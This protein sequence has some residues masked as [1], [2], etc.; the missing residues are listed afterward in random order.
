MILPPP[1]YHK[2]IKDILRIIDQKNS[3]LITSHLAP[4]GDSIGS[5][6][7]LGSFLRYLGKKVVIYNRDSVPKRYLFLPTSRKIHVGKKAPGNYDVARILDCGEMERT[8]NIID[9][10][11]QVKIS[12]DIDHHMGAKRFADYSYI[13]VQASSV[14]EQI[15][16]LMSIARYQ[17]DKKE[18]I[19]LYT[20]ILTDT[21]NFQRANTTS[22]TLGICSDLITKG[23][24]PA[25]LFSKIYQ[26]KSAEELRLLGVV[27][28]SLEIVKQKIGVLVLKEWMY[29][30]TRTS[31]KD[32]EGIVEY[33]NLIK[34]IK[35]GVLFRPANG[36]KRK[37]W[38]VTFRST[39]NVNV[40][41]VA[42]K[43][44]GGGHF[45]AAGCELQGS[46]ETVKK[47][48]LR[49]VARCL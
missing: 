9:L 15:Y 22:Q 46:L 5:Q 44:G 43:F 1:Q 25:Y 4:D 8:G 3:F 38:R 26:M 24:S 6:L 13:D 7:A 11:T 41:S 27:L 49:E 14:C 28:R 39:N 10:D 19:C 17:P 32:A 31:K 16:N 29:K 21:G 33:L 48:V 30:A 2:V 47:K 42:K 12:I 18:S 23:V 40:Q 45:R 35:V 36:G 34:G 20:G 37:S